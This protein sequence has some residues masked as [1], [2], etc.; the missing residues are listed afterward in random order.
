MKTIGKF[1]KLPVVSLKPL[2]RI[3]KSV[4]SE[5]EAIARALAFADNSKDFNP[6]KELKGYK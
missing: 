6:A 4:N 5:G 1:V 3:R 2:K